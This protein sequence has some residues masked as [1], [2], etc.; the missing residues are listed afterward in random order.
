MTCTQDNF[1]WDINSRTADPDKFAEQWC[2]DMLLD[3][4][5]VVPLAHTIRDQVLEAR[6]ACCDC[7]CGCLLV[8]LLCTH[9]SC[10]IDCSRVFLGSLGISLLLLFFCLFLQAWINAGFPSQE[11]EAVALREYLEFPDFEPL[12]HRLD[13]EEFQK[14][15]A[16][17]DRKARIRR[18]NKDL[19]GDLPQFKLTPSQL[20]KLSHIVNIRGLQWGVGANGFF[21]LCVDDKSLCL[22]MSVC[23][24]TPFFMYVVL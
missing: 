1:Q 11:P 23:T 24:V 22:G 16:V 13:E 15:R 20:R 18:R 19:F 10:V 3:E 14:V 2:A 8:V 9:L 17:E 12:V 7:L 4:R 5:F 21:S 6:K